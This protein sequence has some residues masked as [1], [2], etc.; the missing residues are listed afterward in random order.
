[1]VSIFLP[2]FDSLLCNNL[3]FLCCTHCYIFLAIAGHKS[4][5]PFFCTLPSFCDEIKLCLV[6]LS[7]ALITD[8]ASL[9]PLVTKSHPQFHGTMV[10]VPVGCFL[11]CILSLKCSLWIVPSRNTYSF[12]VLGQMS[13]PLRILS[14]L[15]QGDY[16]SSVPTAPRQFR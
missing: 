14:F 11:G 5:L 16:V 13:A 3:W 12:Y 15:D 4:T 2:A 10:S 1:M 9:H 7:L 6:F 8:L